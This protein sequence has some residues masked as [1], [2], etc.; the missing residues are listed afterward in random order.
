MT[1]TSAS[2]DAAAGHRSGAMRGVGLTARSEPDSSPIAEPTGADPE[3]PPGLRLRAFATRELDQALDALGWRG[4][5]IHAGVH[6]A[7]KC[8]R[9]T[10]AALALGGDALGPGAALVDR[11]LRGLN[12]NLSNLRDAHALVETLDRLLRSHAEAEVRALLLRAR[13]RA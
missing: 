12:L 7:R 10:R 6:L 9:R 11:E 13:R 4:N 3:R 1:Q 8:L 2:E 5:R